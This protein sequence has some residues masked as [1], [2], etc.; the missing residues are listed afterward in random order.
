MTIFS[1]HVGL[2][3]QV[4]HSLI[5]NSKKNPSCVLFII[6]VLFWFSRFPTESH[7]R[8]SKCGLS[9]L[10]QSHTSRHDKESLSSF[11]CV[12]FYLFELAFPSL[13]FLNIFRVIRKMQNKFPHSKK[14]SQHS[15]LGQMHG[16]TNSAFCKNKKKHHFLVPRIVFLSLQVC[17]AS[18]SVNH[19]LIC[20]E[21]KLYV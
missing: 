11:S 9:L 10:R 6:I 2:L 5:N 15:C 13:P 19:I 4:P 20:G 8:R 17:G 12:I 7:L 14:V 3:A 1:Y 18:R 16:E 21:D